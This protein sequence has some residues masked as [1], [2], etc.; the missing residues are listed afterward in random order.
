MAPGMAVCFAEEQS[1]HKAM[2]M[3][4]IWVRMEA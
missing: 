4:E 3:E 1:T 2:G